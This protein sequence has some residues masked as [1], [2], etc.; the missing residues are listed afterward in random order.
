VFI[1]NAMRKGITASDFTGAP[2]TSTGTTGT[3]TGTTGTPIKTN[4][5]YPANSFHTD[6]IPITFGV[7]F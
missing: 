3:S 1:D 5:F 4:N 7:R 6:Y 2:G